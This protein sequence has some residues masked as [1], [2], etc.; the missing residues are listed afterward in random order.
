LIISGALD[1]QKKQLPKG[2]DAVIRY[3]LENKGSE[4]IRSIEAKVAVLKYDGLKDIQT[5]SAEYELPASAIRRGNADVSAD[6]LEVGEYLAI[7]TA[8][9]DGVI[10][11]LQSGSFTVTDKTGDTGGSGGGKKPPGTVD[12]PDITPPLSGGDKK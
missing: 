6:K 12:L 8:E 4:D 2:E 5:V 10:Y 9:A 3:S 7:Y 11:P 1:I